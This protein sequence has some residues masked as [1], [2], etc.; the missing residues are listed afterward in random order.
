MIY[1]SVDYITDFIG[2]WLNDVTNVWTILIRI[3][4]ATICAGSIG[5]E[6]TRKRHAAGLR[7]YI[8]VCLGAAIVMM[9]SEY[10]CIIHPGTDSARLGAQ[11]I[12]GIGFLGAGSILITSKSRIK[13][14]TTAAGLWTAA[15]MGLAIGAGFY[16]LAIVADIVILII[17]SLMPSVEAMFRRKTRYFE[18][19]VEL[20]TRQNLKDLVNFLRGINVKITSIEKNPAYL[21]SGLSVYTMMLN[22]EEKHDHDT[23]ISTIQNLEYVN[24]CEEIN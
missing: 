15:C 13:G 21:D 14:L 19:H 6:R 20:N 5:F 17:L 9:L 1:I 3:F 8:L 18:L 23:F 16:T 10:L 2:T 11:V 4:L 12:S 7:T 24:F 22:S